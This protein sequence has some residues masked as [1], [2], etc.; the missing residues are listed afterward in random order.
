MAA[1][2]SQS[3]TASLRKLDAPPLWPEGLR[4]L[5]AAQVKAEVLKQAG[6]RPWDRDELDRR[7]VRQVIEGKG[8]I[9]DS[10]EQ[11]GGYPK[12]AMTTRKLAVPR[13]NIEAW[14]ASFCPATF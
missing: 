9:I 4:A 12:P 5:P 6:A 11:V 14:L 2:T 7:I 8:R 13:E 10:Q 1:I 3:R